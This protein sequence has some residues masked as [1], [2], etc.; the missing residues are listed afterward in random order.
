MQGDLYPR[1]V[2]V[3]I[4][5]N[6]KINNYDGKGIGKRRQGI[7]SPIVTTQWVKHKGPG[8]NGKGENPMTMKTNFV[9]EKDIIELGF[10]S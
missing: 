2:V 5:T 7:L 8:F 1:D 9:K 6:I 10:S 3:W 4:L